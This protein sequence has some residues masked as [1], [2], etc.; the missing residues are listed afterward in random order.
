MK[1]KNSFDELIEILKKAH[2]FRKI[3]H[4]EL[5]WDKCIRCYE[6]KKIPYPLKLCDL[7]Q[8]Q[9]KE[10]F[11]EVYEKSRLENIR[12]YDLKNIKNDNKD[13][14]SRRNTG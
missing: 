11:P 1:I 3:P 13:I 2:D 7:C 10:N 12:L 9:L 14:S 6:H 5:G 8:E 4:P